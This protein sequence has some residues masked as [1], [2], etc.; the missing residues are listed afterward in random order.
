MAQ[1][2]V[3]RKRSLGA[4]TVATT[5]LAWMLATVAQAQVA[6]LT[7]AQRRAVDGAGLPRSAVV[8]ANAD[9]VVAI[10]GRGSADGG[11]H[12]GVDLQGEVI[13]EQTAQGLGYRSMR[14]SVDVDCTRRRDLVTKMTVYS[15]ARAKGLAIVRQVP[16]DWAQP[17]PGAYLAAVNRAICGTAAPA[18]VISKAAASPKASPSPRLEAWASRPPPPPPAAASLSDDPD[19]PMTTAIEAG[20]RTRAEAPALPPRAPEHPE[21]ASA[22]TLRGKVAEPAPPP[23][24]AWKPRTAAPGKV[25]VQVSASATERQAREALAKLKGKI[26]A[27]LS[28]E[29]RAAV[30]DGRTYHR[31]IIKGF[32]NRAEAQAFCAQIASGCFV[33]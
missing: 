6:Q 27:P 9:L 13:S 12:K 22:P 2:M 33:R 21:P 4:R 11:I 15:E 24:R 29:V 18:P 20:F 17:S 3:K 32:Q 25:A 10:R 8:F 30:V 7:P 19:A 14:S 23:A 1:V 31:A 16:G 28:T 26:I 5:A